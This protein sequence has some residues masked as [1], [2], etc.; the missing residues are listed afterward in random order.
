MKFKPV[1]SALLPAIL[2]VN[3]LVAQQKEV[4]IYHPIQTD[5][6]GNIIP[7]YNADQATAFDHD[8]HI[9][10]DFWFHIRRDPNGLPYY[11]NHQ[12]FNPNMDDLRAISL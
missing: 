10:W 1:L 4:L 6:A 5:K 11:M 2:A 8:L 12:V 7:W 9:I 3:T